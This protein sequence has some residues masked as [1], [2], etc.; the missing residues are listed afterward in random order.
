MQWQ[1]RVSLLPWRKGQENYWW[2]ELPRSHVSQKQKS[3]GAAAPYNSIESSH[4]QCE[5]SARVPYQFQVGWLDFCSAVEDLPRLRSSFGHPL[6]Y[7]SQGSGSFRQNAGAKTKTPRRHG[8][9]G[10]PLLLAFS[11]VKLNRA[12]GRTE[13]EEHEHDAKVC[14]TRSCSG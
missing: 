1:P 6:V 13:P 3:D 11:G 7:R 8:L 10:E 9:I 2:K 14:N 12:N 5:P 4:K